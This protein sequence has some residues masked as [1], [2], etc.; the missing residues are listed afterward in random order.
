MGLNFFIS[1]LT[2]NFTHVQAVRIVHPPAPVEGNV[3]QTSLAAS[4]YRGPVWIYIGTHSAGLCNANTRRIGATSTVGDKYIRANRFP[5]Y[6][7]HVSYGLKRG[8]AAI[9]TV[10]SRLHIK[11]KLQVFVAPLITHNIE[12]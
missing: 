11:I 5:D 4:Y 1:K 7:V 12:D 2:A 8:D 9:V 3:M 6:L 10:W